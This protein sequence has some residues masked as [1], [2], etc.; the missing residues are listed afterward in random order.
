MS[1]S[2]GLRLIDERHMAGAIRAIEGILGRHRGNIVRDDA[3]PRGRVH[4]H[5]LV[6]EGPMV[7]GVGLLPPQQHLHL[8]RLQSSRTAGETNI[9]LEILIAQ[10]LHR[11]RARRVRHG[12]DHDPSGIQYLLNVELLNHQ[13]ESLRKFQSSQRFHLKRH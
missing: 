8:H 9:P 6:P 5:V 3:V 12:L 13:L 2:V 4:V 1:A 10:H 7:D 11:H